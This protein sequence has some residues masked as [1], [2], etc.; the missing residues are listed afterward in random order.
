MLVPGSHMDVHID[1]QERLL[2]QT[3]QPVH[4]FHSKNGIL[5]WL[6]NLFFTTGV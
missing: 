2:P 1:L 4:H 5:L 3:L 6:I